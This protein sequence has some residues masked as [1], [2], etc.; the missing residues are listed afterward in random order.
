MILACHDYGPRHARRAAK[1]VHP[2]ALN[3]WTRPSNR[4]VNPL[5]HSIY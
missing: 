3:F 1:G 4:G 2:L 5:L